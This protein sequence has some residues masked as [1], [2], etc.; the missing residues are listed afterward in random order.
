MDTKAIQEQIKQL[1]AQLK[2]TEKENKMKI[3]EEKKEI[4]MKIEEEKKEI[5]MKAKDEKKE[6]KT[7]KDVTEYLNLKVEMEKKWFKLLNPTCYV[8]I[9]DK[10]LI[11]RKASD[12]CENLKHIRVNIVENGKQ[13]NVPFFTLW[14]CD[15]EI[16]FYDG[17]CYAP[18][19]ATCLKNHYNT[20]IEPKHE[21]RA[22][23][24]ISDFHEHLRS[25]V[26]YDEAC[27]NYLVYYLADIVQNPGQV[28][29]SHGTSIIFRGLQGTGKGNL[30]KVLRKLVGSSNLYSTSDI[31]EIIKGDGNRFACG[32]VD[33]LV[34]IIDEASTREGY[35]K[36]DQLKGAIT[37]E[38][39]K[40]E[41][42]GIQGIFETN[43][44]GRYIV[45]TN[46]SNSMK[47][48]HSDRRFIVFETST[49][50]AGEKGLVFGEK[51]SNNYSND[52]YVSTVRTFLND[53]VIPEDFSFKRDRPL[54][55]AYH[56]MKAHNIPH[57]ARFIASLIE[58]GKDKKRYKA[59]EFFNCFLD[60]IESNN[61]KVHYTSTA[62][63]NSL[64]DLSDAGVTKAKNSCM[65]YAIDSKPFRE[66]C[67]EKKYNLFDEI[68]DAND[69]TFYPKSLQK[70]ITL[71]DDDNAE[72][73]KSDRKIL[74]LLAEN[75]LLKQ[76]SKKV[77]QVQEEEKTTKPV[78]AKKAIKKVSNCITIKN[79]DVTINVSKN[80]FDSLFD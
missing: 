27:Y 49:K 44:Y 10:G 50:Y 78:P 25:L 19:R 28:M 7:M 41:Q 11:M 5:K 1:Q 75:V 29:K 61:F 17:L 68:D 35:S 60:F 16:R 64:K 42:K 55:E 73:L 18:P 4:K 21:D 66:Y 51:M 80:S 32:A 3:K 79:N 31:N 30:E 9:T 33:K 59:N 67:R 53:V 77:K 52:D 38:S 20:Y 71:K 47:I 72:I 24:D 22:N 62:F 76:K 39:I 48:E 12:T 69:A 23:V 45:F 57:V 58:E 74:K 56:S 43:F 34:I 65:M 26:N 2:Q 14:S 37:G 46:H 36:A 70:S 13:K 6:K 63:Y 40:Y 54:T 8:E 15:P